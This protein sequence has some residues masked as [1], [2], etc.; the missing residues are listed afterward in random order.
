MVTLSKAVEE[1]VV[2]CPH[3]GAGEAVRPAGKHRGGNP[4]YACRMCNKTFCLNPGTTAH[5]PEFR[6]MVLRAYQE[7]SSM[8]GIVRTFGISRNTLYDWLGEK[9]RSRGAT[10]RDAAPD[11]RRRRTGV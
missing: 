1:T 11:A 10:V 9:K 6:E 3:C 5:P 7:R 2:L 8:R 4:R